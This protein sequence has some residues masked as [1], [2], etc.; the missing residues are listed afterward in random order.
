LEKVYWQGETM[1][2]K[3]IFRPC[4]PRNLSRRAFTL[5]EL[6]VVISIV[7]L[8]M[9]VL[10]PTLQRVR[11]QA[12]GVVC[13]SRLR[14][15]GLQ[16]AIYIEEHIGSMK[17]APWPDWHIPFWYK[18]PLLDPRLLLCPSASTPLAGPLFPWGDAF[19]AYAFGRVDPAAAPEKRSALGYASYGWN[20]W[21]RYDDSSPWKDCMWRTRD[22]KGP[23]RV[24]VLFDCAQ[25]VAGLL[26][27]DP[28]PKQPFTAPP[29]PDSSSF[30]YGNRVPSA[31][32]QRHGEGI[33]MLFLDWSVR[34]VGLKELWTLKWHPEY[35]TGGPWTRAGG[36]QPE[37][38][39]AWM[40]KFK[41]Y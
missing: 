3:G 37:Q 11:K 10:L 28:P 16:S 33:K 34:Q 8:L 35:D 18:G 20:G 27:L 1:S 39:P 15:L 14:E 7:A 22:V 24:P 5:I 30:Y 31:C 13:Q 40:R 19:H 25:R 29:E 9:A 6:L 17:A 12:K 26:H 23:S 32:I 36:V 38:W 21:L 2:G 41:D 4:L